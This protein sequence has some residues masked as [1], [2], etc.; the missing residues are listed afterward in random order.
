M[1]LQEI[2]LASLHRQG[3]GDCTGL[4][5]KSHGPTAS[6]VSAAPRRKVGCA[7]EASQEAVNLKR[8]GLPLARTSS[9]AIHTVFCS[10]TQSSVPNCVF[11]SLKSTPI[12]N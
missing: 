3:D 12:S 1:E 8:Q 5:G 10:Y 7:E 4:R 9:K 11:F 2:L 6:D